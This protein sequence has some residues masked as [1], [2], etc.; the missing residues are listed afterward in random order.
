MGSFYIILYLIVLNYTQSSIRLDIPAIPSKN[1]AQT[2]P[3]NPKAY[4]FHSHIYPTPINH[5]PANKKDH[6]HL[7][8]S[9]YVE[10][11]PHF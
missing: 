11:F 3:I 4:L 7:Y 1:I 2:A 6:I 10:K 5:Q 9:K 8:L